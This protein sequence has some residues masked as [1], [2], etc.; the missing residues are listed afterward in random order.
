MRATRWAALVGLDTA[1]LLAVRPDAGLPRR[2][3]APHAWI[4]AEGVD[5]A[6]AQLAAAGL[7]VAAAWTALGL[8][9]IA[10]TAMPGGVGRA[11]QRVAQVVLPRA[12][13]RL[14][15]GATG[16]GVLLAPVAAS[17]SDEPPQ[18]SAVTAPAWPTDTALPAP[19]WP[20]TAPPHTTAPHTA[21]PHTAT[22]HTATPHTATPHTATPRHHGP[23]APARV[24]ATSVTVAAGDSLWS[25]AAAH[26]DGPPSTRRIAAEWPRWYAANRA[27]VG[28]DPDHIVPGQILSAPHGAPS[29]HQE[30][31]P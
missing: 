2:L 15:A 10:G 23:P 14:A 27:V 8:L 13:Y 4:A 16:V 7:W 26:L 1:V 25:I 11:A 22:P 29:P 17:A 20:T 12:V 5:G 30:E 24:A 3:A 6:A 19:A 28:A 18:R 9:S 21:T 31:T